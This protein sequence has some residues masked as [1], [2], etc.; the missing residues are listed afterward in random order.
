MFDYSAEMFHVGYLVPDIHA[1]MDD[2]GPSLGLKW[3][4]VISRDDQPCW[5]PERGAFTCPLTFAYST[6]GPQ[7]VELIQGVAGTVWDHQGA[8]H[9][10]HAG[11]WVRCTGAHRLAHQPRLGAHCSAEGPGGRLRLLHLCALALRL[12]A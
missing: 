12:P 4:Q 11:V 8:G 2:L 7:R 6:E 5:T 1:A 10:H 3:T 9:L